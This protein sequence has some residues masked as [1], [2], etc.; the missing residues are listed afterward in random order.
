[1]MI[2]DIR[3]L[4]AERKYEDTLSFA[5]PV[6]Q[7]LVSLPDVELV[8]IRVEGSYVIYDDDS[9]DVTG[10]VRYLLRG[11]CTRCLSPAEKWVEAAWN[12]CYVKDEPDEDSYLYEKGKIDLT[13]SVKDTVAMSMPYKLLCSSDCAG[14]EYQSH[15]QN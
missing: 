14:I 15:N 4:N 9:V 8:E 3:K 10:K 7:S 2:L 11:A 5:V 12:A 1:M 6:D 13:Q